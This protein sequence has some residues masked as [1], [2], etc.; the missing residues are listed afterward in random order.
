MW[1]WQ[2]PT[3]EGNGRGCGQPN[4]AELDRTKRCRKLRLAEEMEAD[5]EDVAR[6]IKEGR[7]EAEGN[8]TAER[9][10]GGR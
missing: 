8:G 3:G 9:E 6:A 7:R 10:S 1:S 4:M 2:C 5:D